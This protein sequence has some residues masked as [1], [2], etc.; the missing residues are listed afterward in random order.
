MGVGIC[1]AEKESHS[2]G[3]TLAFLAASRKELEEPSFHTCTLA[4]S[5]ASP[6][7][8]HPPWT[9]GGGGEPA[10][11]EAPDRSRG[12]LPEG[13]SLSAPLQHQTSQPP[14]TPLLSQMP[15]T[16]GSS[17]PS[18]RCPLPPPPFSH[19]FATLSLW[20][21]PMAGCTAQGPQGQSF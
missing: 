17:V 13:F 6:G 1:G 4:A 12:P 10:P 16:L 11:L 3:W 8:Q 20:W 14:P 5:L 9:G 15:L 19:S 18:P 2:M 21:L 7:Q